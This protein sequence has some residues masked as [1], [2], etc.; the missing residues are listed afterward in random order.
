[1]KIAVPTDDG[2]RIAEHFG[3]AQ[4]FLIFSIEDGKILYHE[5]VDSMSPHSDG[6]SGQS[7]DEC[8]WFMPLLEGSD[9]IISRGMGRRAVG[10][11][12]EAGIKPVFT[13]LDDA[14]E[15]V[16]AYANGTLKECAQPECGHH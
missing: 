13:D 16:R 3:R 10:H 15:A 11:F 9:V 2:K 7:H 8:A 4:S 5:V 12:N 6:G 14:E 1:M